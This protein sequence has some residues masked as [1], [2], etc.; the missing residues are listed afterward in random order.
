MRKIAIERLP[1]SN[2]NQIHM[3]QQKAGST[4]V[5]TLAPMFEKSATEPKPNLLWRKNTWHQKI[6]HNK[7]ATC[8]LLYLQPKTI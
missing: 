2:S 3:C 5:G 4:E 8:V 1:N 6:K 7:T